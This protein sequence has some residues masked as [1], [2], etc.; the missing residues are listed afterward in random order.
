MALTGKYFREDTAPAWKVLPTEAGF[1]A[2][3]GRRV[4]GNKRY[5][6]LN[7]FLLPFYTMIPPRPGDAQL[8]RMWVPMNDERCWVICV[9]WRPDAP[10]GAQELAAWRNGENSHRKVIPGTTTNGM[11]RAR[12]TS[13]SSPP[14][15]NM[16]GSPPLRRATR[17]PCEA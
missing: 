8:V 3:N 7:Q 17:K 9:T 13:I 10:L 5:W 15:P 12:S 4:D 16:N 11:P 2:C 1:V 6:R 14:R